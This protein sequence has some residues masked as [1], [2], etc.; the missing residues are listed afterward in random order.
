MEEQDKVRKYFHEHFFFRKGAKPS[1]CIKAMHTAFI[2]K[3]KFSSTVVVLHHIAGKVETSINHLKM[4]NS[5]ILNISE[6]T[7][8]P[9]PSSLEKEVLSNR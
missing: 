2:N 9:P 5:I 8:V 3:A 6:S 4:K 1:L 7:S